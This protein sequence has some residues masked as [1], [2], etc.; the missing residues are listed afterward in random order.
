[1]QADGRFPDMQEVAA[2]SPNCQCTQSEVS[3]GCLFVHIRKTRQAPHP[4]G[5]TD[6]AHHPPVPEE[7]PAR[8]RQ[9]QRN[10]EAESYCEGV[11]RKGDASHRVPRAF[12]ENLKTAHARP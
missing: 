5:G 10:K 9:I 7:K 12:R 6:D 4:D 2:A 3:P 11:E 8:E 1:M